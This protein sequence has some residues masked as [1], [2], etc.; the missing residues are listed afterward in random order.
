MRWMLNPAL[1]YAFIWSLILFLYNLRLSS[2]LIPFSQTTFLFILSSIL[3]F[4]A[5][6]F[7]NVLVTGRF[8]V[9]PHV[10]Q[11]T[12]K[13]WVFSRH[14]DKMLKRLT[15]LFAVGTCLEIVIAGNLP[16]LSMI[17]VGDSIR[18]T[19]FGIRGIH[20]LFNASFLIICTILYLRQLSTPRFLYLGLLFLAFIWPVLMLTRQLSISLIVQLIFLRILVKGVSIRD[21]LMVSLILFIIIL[22]FGYIG[23]M[24]SSR[25]GMIALAQP[26]F[27][28]PEHLPSG[29][30]WVYL[31]MTS[32]TNNLIYNID[33]TPYN[34][35]FSILSGFIPSFTRSQAADAL[36][37]PNTPWEMVNATLNVATMHRKVIS[38]FGTIYGNIFYYFVSFGLGFIL[39]KSSHDPRFGLALVVVLHGIFLSFFA[40]FLFHLVFTSQF[41]MYIIFFKQPKILHK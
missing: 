20:G 4:L 33:T 3:I 17:G 38:D 35:P 31:Y 18:Y 32:P 30:M 8:I 7:F 2:V 1:L 19:K 25:D 29:F 40:D 39:L 10:N 12:Y 34:A 41:I 24:R 15:I 5:G 16:L 27:E 23:D 13:K 22:F 28:Y 14:T 21:S 36:G 37:F 11:E 26:T 6:Y 9:A